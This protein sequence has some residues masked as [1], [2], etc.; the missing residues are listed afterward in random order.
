MRRTGGGKNAY[1]GSFAT[2]E[3]AAIAYD[4]EAIACWGAK[5]NMSLACAC[6]GQPWLADKQHRAD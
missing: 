5:V 4:T 6:C 3:E 2:E 1:L